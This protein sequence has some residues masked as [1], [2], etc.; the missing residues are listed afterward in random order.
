MS[1][2]NPA[3]RTLEASDDV[4]WISVAAP[5]DC[6]TWNCYE[7]SGKAFILSSDPSNSEAAMLVK[8]GNSYGFNMPLNRGLYR[9]T[10]GTIITYFQAT[11]SNGVTVCFSFGH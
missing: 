9:Y 6:C 1:E 10:M 5:I 2:C 7:V 4:S 3:F 11:D 8:A